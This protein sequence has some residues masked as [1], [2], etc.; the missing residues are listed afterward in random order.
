MTAEVSIKLDKINL[1]IL[2][3]MKLLET[4]LMVFEL[5]ELSGLNKMSFIINNSTA[6]YLANTV[7][8]CFK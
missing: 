3:I 6:Y 1:K 4:W 8:G 5:L 2:K 7:T